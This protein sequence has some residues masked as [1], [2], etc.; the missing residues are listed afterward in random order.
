MG[1]KTLIC[2]DIS[3][4]GA[5][6]GTNRQLYKELASK[7]ALQL[8][9]SGG[10]STL[11]D[12]RPQRHE[13]KDNRRACE[14]GRRRTYRVLEG[15]EQIHWVVQKGMLHRTNEATIKRCND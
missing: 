15:R 4:D 12:V 2:T 7:F 13:R 3:R 1:V 6:R 5:M 11:D 10:V 8:I 14:P 9:A